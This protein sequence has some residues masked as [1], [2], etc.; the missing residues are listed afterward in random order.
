VIISDKR[1]I[2]VNEKILSHEV[3]LEK[4]LDGKEYMKITVKALALG[5]ASKSTIEKISVHNWCKPHQLDRSE[6]PVRS[7]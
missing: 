1:I 3:M 4:T 5:G 7:V 2:T 6:Q